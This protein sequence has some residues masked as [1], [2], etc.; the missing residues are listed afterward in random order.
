MP[1]NMCAN[2]HHWESILKKIFNQQSL[3]T[4]YLKKTSQRPSKRCKHSKKC[5]EHPKK[6]PA[7][8]INMCIQFEI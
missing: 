8:Y 1:L 5:N 7:T 6:Q 4:L 3:N 2:I